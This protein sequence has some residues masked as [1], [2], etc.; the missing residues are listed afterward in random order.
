MSTDGKPQDRHPT[1]GIGVVPWLA[2]ALI[3]A[4]A[5]CQSQKQN[6]IVRPLPNGRPAPVVPQLPD[7]AANLSQAKSLCESRARSAQ[8]AA[9]NRRSLRR[10]M[11]RGSKLYSET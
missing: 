5:V 1:I 2:L 8:T 9:R 11:G 6:Q 4:L 3:I 7:L 10:E